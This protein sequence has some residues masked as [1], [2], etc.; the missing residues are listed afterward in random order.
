MN[1][2]SSNE[3]LGYLMEFKELVEAQRED[4]NLRIREIEYQL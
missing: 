3:A 4:L 2:E 1:R